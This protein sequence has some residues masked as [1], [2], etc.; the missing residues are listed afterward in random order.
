MPLFAAWVRKL[1]YIALTRYRRPPPA[2]NP[3][4]HTTTGG[5]A[6]SAYLEQMAAFKA[7]SCADDIKRR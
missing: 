1:M 6:S 7:T 2:Q 5:S 3:E 4:T